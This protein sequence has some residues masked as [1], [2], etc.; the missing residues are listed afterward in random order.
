MQI[1]NN[2]NRMS[3]PQFGMALK[4]NNGS[5]AY[6]KKQSVKYLNRLENAGKDM[7]DFKYFDLVVEKDGLHIKNKDFVNSAYRNPKLNYNSD[8]SKD[9]KIEVD[10]DGKLPDL[11]GRKLTLLFQLP[12]KEAKQTALTRFETANHLEKHILL[13]EMLEDQWAARNTAD[14]IAKQLKAEKTDLISNLMSKFSAAK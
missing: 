4:L 1:N 5:E 12:T 9:I 8:N 7:V 13:T 3:T 6:L 11:I 14:A 2:F 10:Y